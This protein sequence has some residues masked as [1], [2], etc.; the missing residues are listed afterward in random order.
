MRITHTRH[1]HWGGK[2]PRTLTG[3]K[4]MKKGEGE[5]K[6]LKI[7]ITLQSEPPKRISLV[8]DES[9][10]TYIIVSQQILKIRAKYHHFPL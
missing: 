10:N 2:T 1:T 4:K 7:Y 8:A 9:Q 6:I 3:T 5:S